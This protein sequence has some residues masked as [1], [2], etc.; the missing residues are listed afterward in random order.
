[1]RPDE[2]HARLLEK[3]R[4]GALVREENARQVEK[5]IDERR[6]LFKTFAVGEKVRF[7]KKIVT[8]D[9]LNEKEASLFIRF[10]GGRIQECAPDFL[11]KIEK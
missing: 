6:E 7:G 3:A 1:M 2:I 8:V 4:K 9:S 11:E 5:Q 10:A